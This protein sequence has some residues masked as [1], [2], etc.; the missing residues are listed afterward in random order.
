MPPK[1]ETGL[2]DF[3]WPKHTKTV[4]LC[5][6]IEH[7]LFQTA[8]THIEWPEN[9]P[10]GHKIYQILPFQDPQ[11]YTEIEIFGKKINH[12]ATLD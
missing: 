1:V 8:I 3:S 10:N 4:K 9:T 5:A 2:P 6:P 11:K 7:E 12:L